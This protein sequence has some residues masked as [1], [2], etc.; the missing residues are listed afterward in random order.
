VFLHSN[1]LDEA[2]TVSN[3][4]LDVLIDACVAGR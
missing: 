1:S 3:V 4:V 2:I